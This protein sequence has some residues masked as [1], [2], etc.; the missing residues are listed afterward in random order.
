M[1]KVLLHI[2]GLIGFTPA[3]AKWRVVIVHGRSH[4]PRLTRDTEEVLLTAGFPIDSLCLHTHAEAAEGPGIAA[5]A[6]RYFTVLAANVATRPPRDYYRSSQWGSCDVPTNPL[7]SLLQEALTFQAAEPHSEVIEVVSPIRM[8]AAATPPP[9]PPETSAPHSWPHFQTSKEAGDDKAHDIRGL[10]PQREAPPAHRH[11]DPSNFEASRQPD[12]RPRGGTLFE[13]GKEPLRGESP[14][15]TE[16]SK[17]SEEGQRAL[18]DIFFPS[19]NGLGAV[20]LK[21]KTEESFGPQ[22]QETQPIRDD[23][24]EDFFFSHSHTQT[25]NEGE[26][27]TKE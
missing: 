17:L 11:V 19:D 5:L 16:K 18:D 21:V 14:K 3:N 8:P 13:E 23:S 12:F 9:P 20:T 4:A 27:I 2:Y 7:P 15:A 6:L 24:F 1:S 22:R 26:K 25:E 10:S